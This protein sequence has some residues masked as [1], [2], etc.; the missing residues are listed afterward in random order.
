MV[1]LCRSET[2]VI[3][4]SRSHC[5]KSRCVYSEI[6]D[7]I[8]EFTIMYIYSYCFW[9]LCHINDLPD[10]V[11][12]QVRLFADDCLIYREIRNTQDHLVLQQDLS[13]MESWAN[14]W[15][16]RFN[17]KK[18]Y[19]LSVKNKSQHYYSLCG[20]VFQH[21]SNNPYL[22]IEFSEDLKWITHISKITKKAS[23]TIGFLHRNLSHCPT[24]CRRNAYLS[25]VRSVIEYGAIVWDPHLQQDVDRL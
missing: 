16:M 21:V 24:A 8:L 23:S 18:C 13:S 5:S 2:G 6:A 3:R 1:S 9:F 14:D 12:S 10:R 22:G 25:L 17:S 15:G 4:N 11:K 19:I 7:L 20:S